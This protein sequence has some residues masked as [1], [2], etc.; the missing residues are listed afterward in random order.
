MSCY[1]E[2]QQRPLNYPKYT[3]YK[4]HFLMQLNASFHEV[5]ASIGHR[6]KAIGLSF[7]QLAG[8]NWLLQRGT[9]SRIVRIV[10]GLIF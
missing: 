2:L 4:K 9:R 6:T 3:G 1:A 10:E 8:G 5:T 7:C